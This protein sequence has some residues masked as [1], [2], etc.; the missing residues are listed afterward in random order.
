MF[1]TTVHHIRRVSLWRAI[2]HGDC[3]QESTIVWARKTNS[4]D[5]FA[6]RATATRRWWWGILE[7]LRCL[8]YWS[9]SIESC[10]LCLLL[11]FLSLYLYRFWHH[12][13]HN[14]LYIYIYICIYIYIYLSIYLSMYLSIYIYIICLTWSDFLCVSFLRTCDYHPGGLDFAVHAAG[15]NSLNN[16][17]FSVAWM[18]HVWQMSRA[19]HAWNLTPK[20]LS[21]LSHLVEKTMGR[22]SSL[23]RFFVLLSHPF[24]LSKRSM[25]TNM[26]S[27][28]EDCCFLAM[29][30]HQFC[31]LWS[32]DRHTKYYEK[33]IVITKL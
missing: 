29:I 31:T 16:A 3:S 5:T 1:E 4:S 11:L 21:S 26:R 18:V 10:C 9:I 32:S 27:W 25:A 15:F 14:I 7:T 28:N 6:T 23:T 12:Y 33:V 2:E 30:S 13:Y 20:P 8:I 17:V 19:K 24:A 22:S